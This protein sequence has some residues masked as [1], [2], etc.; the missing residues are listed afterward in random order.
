MP[1][2]EERRMGFRQHNE[3][4]HEQQLVFQSWLEANRDLIARSGL[5]ECVTRSRDDW[6]Y[7]LKF[8]YHNHGNWNTP[9][10]TWIDFTWDQLSAEQQAV[11]KDLEAL[12]NGYIREHPILAKRLPAQRPNDQL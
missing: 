9:P 10:S 2:D 8:G 5:P 4:K 12:W 6:A 7:F 11:I 3:K 1:N